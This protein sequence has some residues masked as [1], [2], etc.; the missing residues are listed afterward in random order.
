[1]VLFIAD[2]FISSF[3]IFPLVLLD[4]ISGWKKPPLL[5]ALCQ[6]DKAKPTGCHFAFHPRVSPGKRKK[7]SPCLEP[8]WGIP[9]SGSSSSHIL[10][11]LIFPHWFLTC[12]FWMSHKVSC[13]TQK[14]HIHV[15]ICISS[16][17]LSQMLNSIFVLLHYQ[18]FLE[19]GA[20]QLFVKCTSRNLVKKNPENVQ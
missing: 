7:L 19:K 16:F 1:M 3:C 15:N 13:Q 17:R 12:S 9:H 8:S 10:N 14:H 6:P 18:C 2:T 4:F 20:S 11:R 5:S